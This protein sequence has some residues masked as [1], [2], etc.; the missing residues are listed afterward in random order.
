MF[1][2]VH[3]RKRTDV[4]NTNDLDRKITEEIDNI[5]R[6]ISYTEAQKEWCHQR[7]HKFLKYKYLQGVNYLFITL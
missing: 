7:A 4:S 3:L 5:Q 1:S 2:Y 6:F